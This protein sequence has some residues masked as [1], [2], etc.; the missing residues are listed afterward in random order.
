[1]LVKL[2]IHEVWRVF[3][4]RLNSET[5]RLDLLQHIKTI[6]GKTYGG[7]FD[8]Y[9]ADLDNDEDS[10]INT[11][12]EMR[13]LVFTDVLTSNAIKTRPYQ[14]VTDY[15]KLFSACDDA[16]N[17]YNNLNEKQLNIVLFNF[18]IEHLLTIARLLKLPGA[19][20]LLVG[21]GGSGRKSLTMLASSMSSSELF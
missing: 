5:D 8:T 9:L 20:A 18:A 7:K 12:S 16:K 21:V 19:N 1:M 11:L 4:D 3:A 17:T 15:N 13:G 2:W 14:M 10:Q 6:T